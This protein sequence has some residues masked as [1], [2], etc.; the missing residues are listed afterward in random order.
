MK[1]FVNERA[2]G[3]TKMLNEKQI[4]FARLLLIGNLCHQNKCLVKK[5]F[6]L[7]CLYLNIFF[8]NGNN[9]LWLIFFYV[10]T[11]GFLVRLC[12]DLSFFFLSSYSYSLK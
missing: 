7:S 3:R 2:K 10:K 11:C 9:H 8:E 1:C 5:K 12:K 4:N 6:S